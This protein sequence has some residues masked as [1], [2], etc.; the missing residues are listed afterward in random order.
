MIPL[1]GRWDDSSPRVVPTVYEIVPATLG[2]WRSK[3]SI[4]NEKYT[5]YLGHR[6]VCTRVTSKVILFGIGAGRSSGEI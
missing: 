2:E 1:Q 3:L 6:F 5:E 4:Y